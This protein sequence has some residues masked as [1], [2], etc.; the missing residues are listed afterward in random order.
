MD[1]MCDACPAQATAAESLSEAFK[2]M[3]QA[4]LRRKV[5]AAAAM[6]PW[7]CPRHSL[8]C[9]RL[10]NRAAASSSAGSKAAARL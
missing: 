4:G 9:A 8:Q 2:A 10:P 6:A 7:Y 3:F 5:L 1:I